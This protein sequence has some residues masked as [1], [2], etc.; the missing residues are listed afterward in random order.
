VRSA[1]AD[2]P[3]DPL[4]LWIAATNCPASSGA[5]QPEYSLIHLRELTPGNA[6]VWLAPNAA[7]D[8]ADPVDAPDESA[9]LKA[10]AAA[11]KVHSFDLDV[12][13]LLL[14]ALTQEPLPPELIVNT[15]FE[16]PTQE[17]VAA[18]LA[19]GFQMAF[20]APQ[21]NQFTSLCNGSALIAH[22]EMRH[23]DCIAAMKN[24]RDRA[25]TLLIRSVA[26]I[27]LQMLFHGQEAAEAVA[28]EQRRSQWQAAAY[29]EL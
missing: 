8:E 3:D 21:L 5:C 20:V 15:G 22:G 7:H 17:K 28:I 13:R 25:D 19:T 27:R 23:A 16:Q 14:D 2:A 29:M 11:T 12:E 26:N 9:R 24:I 4:L 18:M 6:I 10:I 1:L